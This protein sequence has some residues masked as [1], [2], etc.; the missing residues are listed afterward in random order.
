MNTGEKHGRLTAVRRLATDKYKNQTWLFDCECGKTC[1]ARAGDVRSGKTSSCGC[2]RSEIST[3]RH[4]KHGDLSKCSDKHLYWVWSSMCRRCS[5][6]NYSSYA[7]YGG[8]GIFVCEEWKDYVHFKAWALENGYDRG[9]QIDRVDND[10]PYM[11]SNCRFVT[12]SVNS[13][14]R[15]TNEYI[16]LCGEKRSQREWELTLGLKKGTIA[17]WKHRN[18]FENTIKK[19]CNLYAK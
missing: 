15:S 13:L 2:L 7:R 10:G 5:D 19:L 3:I 9:L 8:R 18:G 14:N 12:P 4:T 6:E 11:P 1:L 16:I 17:R